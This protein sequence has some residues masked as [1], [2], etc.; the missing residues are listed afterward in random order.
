MQSQEDP[1][2]ETRK[3]LP[4]KTLAAQCIGKDA[5]EG[6]APLEQSQQSFEA[7]VQEWCCKQEDVAD[8]DAP[9][10]AQGLQHIFAE[11]AAHVLRE[12]IEAPVPWGVGVL[13]GHI[14]CFFWGICLVF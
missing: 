1:G 8:R 14:F 5:L 6:V 12:S 13:F 7:D 11:W 2:H 4:N 3:E 10:S 9:R